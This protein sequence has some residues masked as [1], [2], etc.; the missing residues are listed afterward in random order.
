MAEHLE[1]GKKAEDIAAHF[2]IE[3]GYQ[4]LHRNYRYGRA[5]ID[6]IVQK[7]IFLVFV[8]VKSLTNL[9][10]GMPEIGVNKHKVAMVTKAADFYVFKNNWHQQIRFDIVAVIFRNDNVEVSHFEDAFY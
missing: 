1:T 4:I 7:G 3:K 9:K 10:F 2:L 5:E 6:L 8:E